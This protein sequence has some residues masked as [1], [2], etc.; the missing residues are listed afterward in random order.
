MFP[1]SRSRLWQVTLLRYGRGFEKET[2]TKLLMTTKVITKKH[3][4]SA[5]TIVTTLL[6]PN[7]HWEL[8]RYLQMCLWRRYTSNWHQPTANRKSGSSATPM[9]NSTIISPAA[10]TTNLHFTL[11]FFCFCFVHN[12]CL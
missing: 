10:N 8:I 7:T 3:S 1:P 6:T 4:N 11:L 9:S 5:T 2:M 12:L